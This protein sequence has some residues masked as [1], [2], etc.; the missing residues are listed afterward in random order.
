MGLDPKITDKL[1]YGYGDR[2]CM[3]QRTFAAF[4]W[5]DEWLVVADQ[6]GQFGGREVKHVAVQFCR[7]PERQRF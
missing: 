3:E 5:D 7:R 6:R 2:L 4:V 1:L